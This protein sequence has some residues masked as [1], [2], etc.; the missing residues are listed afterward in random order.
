MYVPRPDVYINNPNRRT[1]E[2]SKIFCGSLSGFQ[3]KK[4]R[5][6][7]I[8]MDEIDTKGPVSFDDIDFDEIFYLEGTDV[9]CT[10]HTQVMKNNKDHVTE[11]ME[12]I[13]T[14]INGLKEK[15]VIKPVKTSKFSQDKTDPSD[16]VTGRTRQKQEG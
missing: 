1:G 9:T 16:K 13:E 6:T 8:F 2:K 10:T 7:E 14:E 5:P 3:D 12:A 4:E 15:G 11:F